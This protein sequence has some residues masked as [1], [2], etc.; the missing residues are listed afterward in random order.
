MRYHT[1]RFLYVGASSQPTCYSG[2]SAVY[3]GF[4]AALGHGCLKTH[5]IA[6]EEIYVPAPLRKTLK[7][8]TTEERAEDILENGMKMPIQ[9]RYD[10]KRYIL[11]AGIESKHNIVLRAKEAACWINKRPLIGLISSLRAWD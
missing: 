8:E 9:V 11:I 7:S 2:P 5:K 3:C 10:G 1:Q 4:D 6:I